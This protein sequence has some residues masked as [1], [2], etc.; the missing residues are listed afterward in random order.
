MEISIW[1]HIHTNLFCLR[2]VNESHCFYK[3]F[4]RPHRNIFY[5][6]VCV[7]VVN[8]SP[9][10][11]WTTEPFEDDLLYPSMILPSSSTLCSSEQRLVLGLY[12]HTFGSFGNSYMISVHLKHILP[13]WPTQTK[14]RF[15]VHPWTHLISVT[16]H[17]H[18]ILRLKVLSSPW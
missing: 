7:R 4:Q 3:V 10:C 2:F 12:I 9:S 8:L 13:G 5:T 18:Y 1:E 17:L 16:R 15:L 11:L 6:V 14:G